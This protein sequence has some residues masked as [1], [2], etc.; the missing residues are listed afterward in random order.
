MRLS[1]RSNLARTLLVLA[2]LLI[3]SQVFSYLTILNYA[4]LP[5][6]K[7]FNS[8]LAYEI[9]VMRDEGMAT[10]GDDNVSLEQTFRR[11]L[12]AKLGC[13]CISAMCQISLKSLT[14]G[15]PLI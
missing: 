12:L 4:L 6:I 3:A 13:H 15:C 10:L 14:G 7:Q 1:P 9:S 11:E 5:S 8:V 2:G